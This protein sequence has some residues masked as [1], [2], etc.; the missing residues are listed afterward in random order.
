[1]MREQHPGISTPRTRNGHPCDQHPRMRGRHP[2]IRDR[3]PKGHR[4]AGSG[5]GRS[6]HSPVPLA[7]PASRV[8]A[9]VTSGC[10]GVT[11]GSGCQTRGPHL[12]PPAGPGV[13][14]VSGGCSAATGGSWGALG[15]GWVLR[16]HRWVLGCHSQPWCQLGD[17]PGIS[18]GAQCHRWAPGCPPRPPHRSARR[19][20]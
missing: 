18:S 11:Q 12:V 1:M 2:R 19:P 16:G 13:P 3:H 17:V 10:P 20:C 6:Q 15:L 7:V 14:L 4:G 5:H 9:A 8:G